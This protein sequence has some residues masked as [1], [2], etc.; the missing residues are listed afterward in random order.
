MSER[1][2][3]IT[4][5]HEES[6]AWEYREAARLLHPWVD[7]FNGAFFEDS[8]ATPFL[9]FSPANWRA[10]GRYRFERNGVGAR[11]EMAINVRHLD[12][13]LP[14]LLATLLH[15]MCHQWQRQYGRAGRTPFHNRE[16]RALAERIGIP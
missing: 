4:R 1:I 14:D 15:Q 12:R 11:D 10:D 5:E 3:E 13:P 2:N 7:R 8:L 6:V 9:V 16:F